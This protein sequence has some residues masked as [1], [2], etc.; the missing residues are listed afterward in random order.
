MHEFLSMR[1]TSERKI[2]VHNAACIPPAA[3][4]TNN[5]RI[6]RERARPFTPLYRSMSYLVGPESTLAV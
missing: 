4:A 3:Y 6:V 2:D 1:R 5:T